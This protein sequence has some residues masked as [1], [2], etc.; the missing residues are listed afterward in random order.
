MILQ[1]ASVDAHED[2]NNAIRAAE[3]SEEVNASSEYTNADRSGSTGG[4]G[5]DSDDDEEEVEHPG[6]AS[7]SKKLWTFFS[8]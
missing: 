3:E 2:A 4:D 8:T 6:E 5:E 1:S 7:I